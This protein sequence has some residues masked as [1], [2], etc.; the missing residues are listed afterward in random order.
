[1]Q[2]VLVLWIMGNDGARHFKEVQS[3]DVDGCHVGVWVRVV[4]GEAH[5]LK[6]VHLAY[7]I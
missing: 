7:K 3:A 4:L 1:M 5:G 6:T 2:G